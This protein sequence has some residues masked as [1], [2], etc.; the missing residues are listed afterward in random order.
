MTTVD[1]DTLLQLEGVRTLLEGA[2]PTGAVQAAD[3]GELVET[4]ELDPLEQDALS[5]ELDQRGIEVVEPSAEP[6]PAP[7]PEPLV[8][9]GV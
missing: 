4:Y 7:P 5:R 2:E 9:V 3:L 1:I 6:E 8:Q